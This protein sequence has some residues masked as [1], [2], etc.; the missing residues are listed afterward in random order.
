MGI[1]HLLV[2]GPN[3]IR[4]CFTPNQ[5]STWPRAKDLARVTVQTD[6]QREIA[7]ARNTPSNQKY[8]LYALAPHGDNY[9]PGKESCKQ[10]T[11]T[12]NEDQIAE[13]KPQPPHPE[14]VANNNDNNN[15]TDNPP[16]QSPTNELVI[17]D[18]AIDEMSGAERDVAASESV[19]NLPPPP[20][21]P[22]GPPENSLQ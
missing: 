12:V 8:Y 22:P 19:P 13:F 21:P 14:N 18:K 20:P 3:H 4:V 11:M 17:S 7:S 6:G 16:Q 9:A 10:Y 5:M 1:G 2:P 15:P